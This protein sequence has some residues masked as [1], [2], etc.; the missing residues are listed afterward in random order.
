MSI[1]MLLFLAQSPY[2][3]EPVDIYVPV[4][5]APAAILAQGGAH[6]GIAEGAAGF[7]FNPASVANRFAYDDGEWWD[8]DWNFDVTA[9]APAQLDDTDFFNSGRTDLDVEQLSS[10]NASVDVQLGRFGLGFALS[11]T[12]IR[13]CSGDAVDCDS[14]DNRTDTA[15]T[16]IRVGVGYAL[17]D[18]EWLVGATLNAPFINFDIAGESI[19]PDI[20]GGRIELGALWR[21]PGENFRVGMTFAPRSRAPIQEEDAG[22][23][24]AGRIV[25]PS[26]VSPWVFGV[27]ASYA[28]GSRPMNLQPAYGDP[29]LAGDRYET[30]SRGHYHAALDLILVGSQSDSVSLD[31]WFAQEAQ[32]IG[33]DLTVALRAGVQGEVLEDLLIARVGTYIEPSRFETT[34]H[35]LHGTGGLD[36]RLFEAIW[37]WRA[38][39][40]FDVTRDFNQVVLSAGFWT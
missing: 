2:A 39:V 24:V 36:L 28:F 37:V 6:I 14:S 32:P 3:N 17:A 18:G 20:G 34:N 13:E 23:V 10:N 9:L 33:R 8:W 11:Q 26:L 25:P 31:G 30:Y 35:R 5:T 40:A 15:V 1:L 16:S 38:G 12:A 19:S 21:P 29:A 4:V 7:T 22:R 27:G